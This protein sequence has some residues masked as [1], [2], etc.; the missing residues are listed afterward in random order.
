MEVVKREEHYG[1]E[2]CGKSTVGGALQEEH[3]GRGGCTEETFLGL[4]SGDQTGCLEQGTGL[5]VAAVS[6]SQCS[7]GTR[8]RVPSHHQGP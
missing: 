7:L 1:D 5:H 4:G 3:C 2:H 8:P 6:S